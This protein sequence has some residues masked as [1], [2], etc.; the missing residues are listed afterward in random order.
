MGVHCSWPIE[1]L[2][3][4]SLIWTKPE[5]LAIGLYS[6]GKYNSEFLMARMRHYKDSR[7]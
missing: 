4:S 6:K 1:E 2:G 5:E 7:F 3:N